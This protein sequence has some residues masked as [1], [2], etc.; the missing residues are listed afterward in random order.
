[1]TADIGLTLLRPGLSSPGMRR[2][3]FLMLLLLGNV[4]LLQGMPPVSA[5]TGK[6]LLLDNE[7]ILE[8]EITRV[9]DEYSVKRDGA[10]EVTL[11]AKRVMKLLQSKTEAFDYLSSKANPN[12]VEDRVKLARWGLIH[13]MHPEAL[14][15][16]EAAVQLN[17]DHPQAKA[18]VAGLKQLLRKPQPTETSTPAVPNQE[19][20]EIDMPAGFNPSSFGP[21]ATKVQPLLMNLCASCHATGKGGD[22]KL[23][24]VF[25]AS[26]NRKG[27]LYNLAST[28]KQIN[29]EKPLNS[30]LLLKSVTAHGD[31]AKAAIRDQEAAPYKVLESWASTAIKYEGPA[32]NPA[33]SFASGPNKTTETEPART[34]VKPPLLGGN[35]VLKPE[36][37]T[38]EL[39]A[40]PDPRNE[41]IFGIE[42]KPQPKKDKESIQPKDEFDPTIFNQQAEKKR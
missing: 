23:I 39:I 15:E 6:V 9:G 4:V 41:G 21:F 16:A 22:F 14:K 31:S 25:E 36:P 5:E 27:T 24:R 7:M 11:P 13:Q 32:T 19:L 37:P 17:P 40:K 28:L 3:F 10:G 26:S 12:K 38:V 8:G 29:P 34:P 18:L 35:V 33:A 20:E 1:M 42:A 2:I 30:T